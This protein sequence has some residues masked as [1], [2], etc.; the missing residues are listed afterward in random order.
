M[1]NLMIVLIDIFDLA[2]QIGIYCAVK[3]N[4]PTGNVQR[5]FFFILFAIGALSVF[6]PLF[7]QPRLY[8]IFSLCIE[9]LK[10]ILQLSFLPRTADLLTI[11]IVFFFFEVLFHSLA[12]YTAWTSN[13]NHPNQHRPPRCTICILLFWYEMMFETQIL[14]LFMDSRSPFRDTFFE[15]LISLSIFFGLI[16]VDKHF[17][18][19]LYMDDVNTDHSLYNTWRL[20]LNILGV[21]EYFTLTITGIVYASKLL[22][23][24]AQLKTYDFIVCIVM[25]ICYGVNVIVITFIAV[26]ALHWYIPKWH[27]RSFRTNA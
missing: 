10:L 21:V 20:I 25:L 26:A 7:N 6:K 15:I 27:R 9:N 17:S 14:L 19:A 22:H 12:L 2:E 18:W 5:R 16:V 1:A 3:G 4:D 11:T 24:S 23:N 13:G 8:I